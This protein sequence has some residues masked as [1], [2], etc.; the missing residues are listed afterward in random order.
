MEESFIVKDNCH[1]LYD[2]NKVF[3]SAWFDRNAL[4][5]EGME[6]GEAAAGRTSALFFRADG[7]EYLLKTYYRGGLWGKLVKQ[8]YFHTGKTYT[9]AFVE[10]RVLAFL[11]RK[12]LPVPSPLAAA[13]CRQGLFYTAHLITQSCRPAVP[14]SQY[15]AKNSLTDDGWAD[16]GRVLHYLHLAGVLHPDLNAHNVLY[17]GDR[18][19]FWLVDFDRS[20][21]RS[22]DPTYYT[23]HVN[24]ARLR[25]SL[26][27]LASQLASFHYT[28]SCFD[29][30]S[31][32][33]GSVI[34]EADT[35]LLA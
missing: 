27:K 13:C 9:R 28:A 1:I 29:S 6:S 19:Q 35:L 18:N 23:Q 33:Y 11:H 5:Q 8:S 30:L 21:I 4:T 34:E 17:D 2:G 20:K 7:T 24:L 31:E 15:L 10:W 14:L 3:D 12:G 32:G 16:L 22:V 25:R 26:E